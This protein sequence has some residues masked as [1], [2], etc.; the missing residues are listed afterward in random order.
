MERRYH[1]SVTNRI[2]GS[3]SRNLGFTGSPFLPGSCSVTGPV[4]STS[5]AL[6]A[7]LGLAD[8]TGLVVER[9]F[10]DTLAQRGGL[11]AYD[12]LLEFDAVEIVD[13][14]TLRR[15]V[16]DADPGGSIEVKVLR[17]GKTKMLQLEMP[18]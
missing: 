14:P 3:P 5:P 4:K 17:R 11:Q 8:G 13:L 7:Q 15:A 1:F 12:I 2:S 9:V 6:R 10:D 16:R 18:Q